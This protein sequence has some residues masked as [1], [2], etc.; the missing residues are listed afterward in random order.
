VLL[1]QFLDWI[2]IQQGRA[3]AR[4][5]LTGRLLATRSVGCDRLTHTGCKRVA[6]LQV[7]REQRREALAAEAVPHLSVARETPAR[8]IAVE[9]ELEIVG[10]LFGAIFL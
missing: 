10:D 6:E 3:D 5:I 4:E 2:V 8:V 9:G 1:D 7:L